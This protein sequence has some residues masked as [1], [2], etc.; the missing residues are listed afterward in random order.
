MLPKRGAAHSQP[1]GGLGDQ[2][3]HRCPC[4]AA[5]TTSSLEIRQ[6]CICPAFPRGGTGRDRA[7]TP[8]PLLSCVCGTS[9]PL[10]SVLPSRPQSSSTLQPHTL[11]QPDVWGKQQLQQ[12]VWQPGAGEVG[13]EHLHSLIVCVCVWCACACVVCVWCVCGVHVCGVCVYVWGGCNMNI[14]LFV[15]SVFLLY[16]YTYVHI[17]LRCCIHVCTYVCVYVVTSSPLAGQQRGHSA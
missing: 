16:V 7:S 1:Q 9:P 6:Q 10:P 4:S 11:L 5:E 13:H 2:G 15:G 14:I 12:F 3:C 17:P 8:L